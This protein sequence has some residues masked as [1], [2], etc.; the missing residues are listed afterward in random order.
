MDWVC[1]INELYLKLINTNS[2][3]YQPSLP[4]SPQQQQIHGDKENIQYHIT[5]QRIKLHGM[6]IAKPI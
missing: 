4:L 5:S 3:W 2:S 1:K 6:L